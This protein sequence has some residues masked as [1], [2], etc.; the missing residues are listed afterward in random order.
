MTMQS[1]M[2]SRYGLVLVLGAFLLLSL[3]I[4]LVVKNKRFDLTEGGL[5]TL[6]DETRQVLGALKN[7][8]T[9]TL[10]FSEKATKDL[11]A[12]RTYAKRVQ[13]LLEE[14]AALSGGKIT[15]KVVDPE[16]FSEAQDLASAAGLQGVP[17]GMRGDEIYFGLVGQNAA[18]KEE[19]ITFFQ[20]DKEKFLEY[21]LSKLVFNLDRDKAPKVGILTSLSMNGGFDFMTQRRQPAW[22]VVQQIEDLY[23]VEW[24]PTSMEEISSDIS[25]LLLVHPKSLP[26]QTLLAIDQFALAGGKVIAFVDPLAESEQKPMQAADDKRS[27]LD[28]LLAKWGVNL[29]PGK[30]VG[31]YAN[32]LVVS[33]G[34][35]RG[36]IRHI[37]LLGLKSEVGSFNAEEVI[38]AGL[39]SMNLSSVGALTQVE[40]ATTRFISL[41][42]T[43]TEAALLDGGL[44]ANLQ[45]PEDLLA[46]FTPTGDIYTVAARLTGKAH[47]AYPE[48]VEITEQAEDDAADKPAEEDGQKQVTRKIMPKLVEGESVNLIVVADTDILTDRL[49]VQVQEFFGQR[50]ATPWADNA[51]FLINSLD[52]LSGN[53]DLINIRSRGKFSRPFTRVEDLRRTAEDKF[54]AQQQALEVQLK[55][56]EAKLMELEKARGEADKSVLTKEQTA[57]LDNFQG[58]KLRIR[59]ALRDVQH[60]LDQDIEALGTTIKLVNIVLLPLLLTLGLM[61]FRLAR[62]KA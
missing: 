24:L 25:V 21:E 55:E 11:P 54:R 37:G 31:D 1:W 47:T 36:P 4:T 9:L 33:M 8:Q 18:G 51:A 2:K 13:E 49:W 42:E 60:Q 62:R 6:S 3:A 30:V 32:S 12:L 27:D 20:P 10:Y 45:N 14:Y 29:S 58:E 34:S 35:R 52:N 41:L 38:L 46:S 15:L 22:M 43:S 40:G 23:Q 17:A 26:P 16:P 56:T 59:K 53:A 39:E 7:P 5:Y 61:L 19:V 28:V 48:G 44:W 57:E 50:I